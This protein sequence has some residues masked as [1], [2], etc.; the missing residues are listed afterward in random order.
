MKTN[1]KTMPSVSIFQTTNPTMKTTTPTFLTRALRRSLLGLGCWL[2]SL[3]AATA[4]N[5]TSAVGA[6]GTNIDRGR[7]VAVDAAGNRYVTGV[8]YSSSVSFGAAGTLTN[9]GG[10]AGSADMFVVKYNASGTPLWA[11]SAG[12]QVP[13]LAPTLRWMGAGMLW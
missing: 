8:F 5:W 4:Q 7:A 12:G 1:R 9:A 2:L 11:R 6:G 10:A 13:I 3:C